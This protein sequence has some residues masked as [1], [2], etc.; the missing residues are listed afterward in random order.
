MITLLIPTMNRSDFLK[1]ALHYYADNNY[2]HWIF[3]GDWSDSAHAEKIK[4][5]IQKLQGKVNIKYKWYPQELNLIKGLNRMLKEVSTPY[6]SIIGDDDFLVPKGIERCVEFL[7]ANMEYTGAHGVG[8]RILVEQDKTQFKVNRISDYRLPPRE[9]CTA[10]ERLLKHMS[11][12]SNVVFS[13]YRTHILQGMFDNAE[14][15]DTSFAADLLPGCLAVVKG[16]IKKLDCFHMVHLVHTGQYM[17]HKDI[18]DWLTSPNW[19]PSY[20]LFNSILSEELSK[21]DNISLDDSRLVVKQALWAYLN[22]KFNN[23]FKNRYTVLTAKEKIKKRFPLL[24][25]ILDEARDKRDGIFPSN[26]TTLSALSS[27]SSPY[28]DDFMPIY[29]AVIKDLS[30]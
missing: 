1:K 27:P 22:Y 9:E 30:R 17:R 8:A 13:A 29:H 5:T 15:P 28:H 2:S 3:I 10:S 25:K 20:Q 26:R 12:M 18:Y 14:L 6:A 16:K 24:K 21:R 23:H 7:D 4:E 11:N 19:F